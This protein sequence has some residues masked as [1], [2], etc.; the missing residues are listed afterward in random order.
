MN[1]DAHAYASA[2]F[3]KWL[4]EGFLISHC[5]IGRRRRIL[6]LWEFE[7]TTANCKKRRQNSWKITIKKFLL[8][9][10]KYFQGFFPDFQYTF[11]IRTALADCSGYWLMLF[12]TLVTGAKVRCTIRKNSFMSWAL[13]HFRVCIYVLV[14]ILSFYLKVSG[15]DIWFFAIWCVSLVEVTV[16][17]LRLLLLFLIES[18][19]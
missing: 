16:H 9:L 17:N 7:K 15:I 3:S 11:F 13:W 19:L 8:L 10:D 5:S 12:F 1:I 18:V 4:T 2:N 14:T 6:L